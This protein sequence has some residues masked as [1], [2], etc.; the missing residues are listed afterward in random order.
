LKLFSLGL[1]H[2]GSKECH[3][4]ALL[5]PVKDLGVVEIADSNANHAWRVFAVVLNEYEH[6]AASPAG[7]SRSAT[8]CAATATAATAATAPGGG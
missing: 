8:R 6:R 4:F 2:C 7:W 3:L 1:Q 5:Y